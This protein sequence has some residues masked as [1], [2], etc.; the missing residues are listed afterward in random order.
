[1][2]ICRVCQSFP[3][4]GEGAG[5]GGLEPHFYYLSREQAIKGHEVTII[6]SGEGDSIENYDGLT[7]I[8]KKKS[9]PF[10]L[11]TGRKLTKILEELCAEKKIDVVHIHNPI[12]LPGFR[13]SG[14]PVVYTIHGSVLHFSRTFMLGEVIR[15]MKSFLEFYLLQKS[16]AKRAEAVTIVSGDGKDELIKEYGIEPGKISVIGSGVNDDF[17]KEVHPSKDKIILSVGRFVRIKGFEYLV[18][19][20]SKV[21]AKHP[22]ATLLLVGGKKGD[23]EYEKLESLVKYLGLYGSIKLIDAVP[24]AK[25]REFYD[26]CQIYV[27]PSLSEGLPKAVLE[28]MACGKP[29]VA[30]RVGGHKDVIL[31]NSNGFLVE[32]KETDMLAERVIELLDDRNKCAKFGERGRE[33]VRK[34]FLWQKI[35]EKYLRLYESLVK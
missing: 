12:I 21:V 25:I 30:T 13:T 10:L 29:V 17:L 19:A 18:T 20:F 11:T 1:M 23:S 8:R 34:D 4:R 5:S 32:P 28:A 31:N 15:S 6:T 14:I 35:G 9:I 2:R 16:L 33:I 24:H 26:N 7:V 22:D 3:R 27:Q